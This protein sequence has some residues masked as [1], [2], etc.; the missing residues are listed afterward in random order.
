MRIAAGD[1]AR[2]WTG[3]RLKLNFIFKMPMLS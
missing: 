3:N 1:F 2:F